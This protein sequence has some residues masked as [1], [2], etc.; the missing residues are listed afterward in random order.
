M[1]LHMLIWLPGLLLVVFAAGCAPSIRARTPQPV[2]TAIRTETLTPT[3]VFTPSAALTNTPTP[4]PT[5]PVEQ[6][7]AKLLELLANNGGCRLPCLW[8]ITPGKSTYQEAQAILAPLQGISNSTGFRTEGG[9]ITPRYTAGDLILFTNASFNIDPL[10]D[11]QIVSYLTFDAKESQDLSDGYLPVYDSKTFG[12]RLSP[13]ML[14][15]ILSELGRPA[16]V[17][18]HTYGKQ[19]TGSGGFEIVILYP[20]QGIFVH[21][22]TQMETVEINVRGCPAN[23]QVELNLYPSGNTEA[24]AKSLSEINWGAF[25]LPEP[26]NDSHWKPIEKATAMSVEQFYETFRQPTDKCIETPVK[27]WYVPEPAAEK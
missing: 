11:N 16:S 25:V 3:P 18:L 2:I 20:E 8:G 7:R 22:T 21:Y 12:E 24:F 9:S 5:L 27:G 10:S 23:A 4:I 17:T 6:A 26:I 13:Y 1:K 14:P 19:I 15:G